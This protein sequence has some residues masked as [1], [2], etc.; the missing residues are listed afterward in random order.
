MLGK[1]KFTKGQRVRPS[2]YGIERMIFAGTYRGEKRAEWSGKV[3]SVDRFNSPRVKWDAL[4]TASGYH[5]DFI[6]PDHRRQT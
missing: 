2:Q 6:E 5:P 3:V 4:K 1:H